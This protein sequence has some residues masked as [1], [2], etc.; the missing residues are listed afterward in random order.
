M[1]LHC[2]GLPSLP[3]TCAFVLR[4]TSD[5][6]QEAAGFQQSKVD[7]RVAY[8]SFLDVVCFTLMM[9][10]WVVLQVISCQQ[11]V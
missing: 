8:Q 6:Y 2:A 5:C 10:L 11:K 7:F 3:A 4:A 9:K 1:R